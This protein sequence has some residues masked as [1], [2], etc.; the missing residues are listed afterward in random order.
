MPA[1]HLADAIVQTGRESMERAIRIVSEH[2]SWGGRVVYG[3][4]DSIFVLFEGRSVADAFKFGRE[5]ADAVTATCPH[6]MELELE[7]VY[8]CC[9][10]QVSYI[11]T[12]IH[13][14]IY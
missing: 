13:V 2:P 14:C 5:M 3:D 11:S 7:K 12:Y 9:M 6:P 8:S 10:L 4:T 1:C